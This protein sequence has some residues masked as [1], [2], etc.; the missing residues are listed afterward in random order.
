MRS[1]P[2]ARRG[3]HPGSHEFRVRFSRRLRSARIVSAA[4]MAP[5]PA[6]VPVPP[7]PA[8]VSPPPAPP[9]PPTPP[10]SGFVQSEAAKELRE[11][12]ERIDA[13]LG[14]M[15]SAADT[16]RADRADR[17]REWQ[18]AAIEL[19]LTIATRV[20]HERIE[21]D[22]FAIDDKLRDMIDQIGDDAAVTVRLNPADLALLNARLGGRPLVPYRGDPRFVAD[23]NLGR[24]DCQVEG[25]ESMLLSDVTRELAEI[26]DELLRSLKNARS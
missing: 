3:S 10:P 22:S 11:D 6:P 2:V 15:K 20:L 16:L 17:L 24:G 7:P 9:A 12:R 26:R 19:A 21:S 5:P 25:R 13:V 1:T 4:E 23:A 18:H 14:A 8:A